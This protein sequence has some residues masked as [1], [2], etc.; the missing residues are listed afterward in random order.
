VTDAPRSA[1]SVSSTLFTVPFCGVRTTSSD[2]FELGWFT[3][4]RFAKESFR[5]GTFGG[6]LVGGAVGS[7]V[8]AVAEG[9]E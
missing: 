2:D 8:V 5:A 4:G 7:S 6:G 1:E 3:L 9:L